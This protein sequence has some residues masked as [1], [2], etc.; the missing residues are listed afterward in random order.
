M[1]LVI[2]FYFYLYVYDYMFRASSAHHQ[3]S[4]TVHAA[5]SFWNQNNV[6]MSIEYKNF[7]TVK[8]LID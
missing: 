2:D 4:L 1:Q 8:S 3:E 5:S 7:K 6:L